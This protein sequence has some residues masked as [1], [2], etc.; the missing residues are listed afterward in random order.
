V[1]VVVVAMTVMVLA[2]HGNVGVEGVEGV[3][4][5]VEGVGVEGVG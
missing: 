4:V 5:G 1:V 3:G 2:G